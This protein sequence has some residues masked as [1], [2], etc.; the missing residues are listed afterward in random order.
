MK[1]IKQCVLVVSFSFELVFSSSLNQE[2]K[3]NEKKIN[4]I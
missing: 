1:L 4:K 3:K 2:K